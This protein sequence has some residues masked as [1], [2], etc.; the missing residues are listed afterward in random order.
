MTSAILCFVLPALIMYSAWYVPAQDFNDNAVLTTATVIS[1]DVYQDWCTETHSYYYGYYTYTYE[2]Y[3]GWWQ[4]E[5][6]ANGQM[7]LAED[8]TWTYDTYGAAWADTWDEG[9]TFPL[10]YHGNDVSN[11]DYSLKDAAT[12]LSTTIAFIVIG[13]ACCLAGMGCQGCNAPQEPLE[14]V[15]MSEPAQTTVVVQQ[16]PQYAQQ[17]PMMVQPQQGYPQQPV[18]YAQQ[19]Q[20][21]AQQS[22]MQQPQQGYP[23]QPQQQYAQQPVYAQQPQQGYAPQT[24]GGQY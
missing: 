22:M 12:A 6:F 10:Y 18:Q 8:T 3:Y 17:Q 19:P 16:Q 1:S 4:M 20:Q 2:C 14:Q 11:F 15:P 5:Y 21:Y 9:A 13:G 7:V 23:Q 24:T